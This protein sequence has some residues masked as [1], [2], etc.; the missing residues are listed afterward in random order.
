MSHEHLLKSE[1]VILHYH[2]ALV[3]QRKDTIQT[4]KTTILLRLISE[5]LSTAEGLGWNAY[6]SLGTLV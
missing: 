5:R 2:F 6:V 1:S 3:E 4:T